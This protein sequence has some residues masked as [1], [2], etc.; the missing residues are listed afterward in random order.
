MLLII[1][2][3]I[4]HTPQF[5]PGPL[6]LGMAFLTCR[7]SLWAPQQSLTFDSFNLGY[8]ETIPGLAF[9]KKIFKQTSYLSPQR[10]KKYVAKLS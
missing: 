2:Q 4:G 1:I 9:G 7:S 3:Y 6:D 5:R 8:I 10:S